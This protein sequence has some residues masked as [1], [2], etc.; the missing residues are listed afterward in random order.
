MSSVQINQAIINSIASAFQTNLETIIRQLADQHNFD[1]VDAL[2]QFCDKPNVV[3]DN[4]SS[5]ISTPKSTPK[6]PPNK[7]LPTPDFALPWT[8]QPIAHCCDAL[9][10]YYGVFSQCTNLKHGDSNFCKTCSKKGE[11]P[12]CGTIYD[13]SKGGF[14]GPNGKKPLH[15]TVFMKKVGKTEEEVR[16]ELDK[17]NIS[18]DD[19]IF[20]APKVGRGRPK[21]SVTVVE[22]SD[23]SPKTVKKAGRPKKVVNSE[24]SVDDLILNLEPQSPPPSLS[25]SL[26]IDIPDDKLVVA[27]QLIPVSPNDSD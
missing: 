1:P 15:Y 25:D 21:K 27:K 13:R 20:V 4:K 16:N 22:D 18:V 3:I 7:K 2:V 12:P 26:K 9:R 17:F 11:A 8:N 5:P 19:D 24:P 6:S 14:V 10:S 23:D